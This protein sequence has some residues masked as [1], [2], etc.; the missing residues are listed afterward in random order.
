M[1][2]GLSDKSP[3]AGRKAAKWSIGPACG[4]YR[5]N[6]TA[7]YAPG[8]TPWS[9]KN[10]LVPEEAYFEWPNADNKVHFEFAFPGHPE[11]TK[12]SRGNTLSNDDVEKRFWE[13]RSGS[14]RNMQSAT[15]FIPTGR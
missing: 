5:R 13:G 15:A 8:T 14:N 7:R 3:D 10:R 11:L 12:L 4:G 1:I 2:S 6:G 9:E